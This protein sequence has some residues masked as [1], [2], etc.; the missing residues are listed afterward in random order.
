MK[1]FK[2]KFLGSF[3]YC[4]LGSGIHMQIM[5]DCCIGTYMAM[6]FDASIPHHLYLAFLPMLSLPNLP[7]SCCPS[8]APLNRLQYVMLP[9]LC[10][11]FSL[12]N[13]QL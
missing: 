4:T 5:Q 13:T 8:H 9:S 1:K 6:W 12:F 10:H 2:D 3:F 7:I 11:V